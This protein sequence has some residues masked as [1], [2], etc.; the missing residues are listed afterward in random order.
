LKYI[1]N[2]QQ[3]IQRVSWK[4]VSC[5]CITKYRRGKLGPRNM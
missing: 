5:F 1:Q 3:N 4:K 2:L